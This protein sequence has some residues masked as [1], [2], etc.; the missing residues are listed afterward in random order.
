MIILKTYIR[1]IVIHRI[2]GLET[3]LKPYMLGDA[4]IHRIGGLEI[5][6]ITSC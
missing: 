5:R 3:R 4:I 6:N 2:G 1:G